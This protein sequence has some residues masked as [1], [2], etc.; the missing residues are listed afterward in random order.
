[1]SSP[2]VKGLTLYRELDPDLLSEQAKAW[3]LR[4]EGSYTLVE[5]DRP[6]AVDWT[7]EVM[8]A[9]VGYRVMY[10]EQDVASFQNLGE[11]IDAVSNAKIDMKVTAHI[12]SAPGTTIGQKAVVTK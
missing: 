4:N 11:A 8:G 7:E 3:L 1:M 6:R 10:G 2:A 5:N 12:P 9:T